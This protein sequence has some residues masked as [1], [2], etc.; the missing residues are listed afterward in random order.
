MCVLAWICWVF[1]LQSFTIP[2]FKA[3]GESSGDVAIYLWVMISVRSQHHP[4]WTLRG[5][6]SF[7]PTAE[8]I[9]QTEL[10]LCEKIGMS[11]MTCL[12][13]SNC[14]LLLLHLS[15]KVWTDT[16]SLIWAA[17]LSL[18][19]RARGCLQL[20]FASAKMCQR[21]TIPYRSTLYVW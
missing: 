12:K 19:R 8:P 17:I 5:W 2:R 20:R 21:Y 9:T 1:W 16:L 7:W 3:D 4:R 14:Q 10:N 15:E 11:E 6:R 13:L 18:S